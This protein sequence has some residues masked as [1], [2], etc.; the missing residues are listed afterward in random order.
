MLFIYN[1]HV[2]PPPHIACKAGFLSLFRHRRLDIRTDNSLSDA[3][4]HVASGKDM[5]GKGS[6]RPPAT[7]GA[8]LVNFGRLLHRVHLPAEAGAQRRCAGRLGQLNRLTPHQWG[9]RFPCPTTKTPSHYII[10]GAPARAPS[11]RRYQADHIFPQTGRSMLEMLAVLAIMGVLAIGGIAAYSFA[12][13]KHRANQIYNQVDLR[14]IASFGNPFVR[15]ATTGQT[16]PLAGFDEVVESIT[17]QHKKTAGNGYDIIASHVPERVCRR[18]QDMTFPVPKSVTLN[19]A[20]LSSTCGSDNTFVFSYDGLSIGKPS[21]GVDP[22]DCTCSG[23]QSCESGVCRDND[24]LCGPKEVCVSGTCQCAPGYTECRGSCYTACADG[25]MRDPVSCDCVCEP[26]DCPEHAS[27]DS[28]TCSCVC[29]DGYEMCNGACHPVC[30]GSGMTG[31]R[32]PDTCACT[33]IEGTDAATCACP[34]GYIYVNGQCQRFECRGGPTSYNCYI[35]ELLC[36]YNC[37]SLGHN[38]SSGTCYADECPDEFDF[39]FIPS[40]WQTSGGYRYG[41]KVPGKECYKI[42]PTDN[43]TFCFASTGIYPCCTANVNGACVTGL[44]DNNL[45]PAGSTLLHGTTATYPYFQYGGCLFENGVKCY[46]TNETQTLWNCQASTGVTCDTACTNPPECNGNCAENMCLDGQTYD[47]ETGYCCKGD[48]CC[49]YN[50]DTHKECYK[51]NTRCATRCNV[52]QPEKCE[53]GNCADPGCAAFGMTYGYIETEKVWG[54]LDS[55]LGISGMACHY[56]SDYKPARCL[57]NKKVCGLRC[58]YDGSDCKQVYMSEC[59]P[60]GECL[61]NGALVDGCICNTTTGQVTTI[62]DKSYCCPAGHIYTNGGCTLTT[63]DDGQIA[64][65]NGICRDA[66]ENNAEVTSTCVC[67][68]STHT[69]KFNRTICCDANHAWDET[70]ETCV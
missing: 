61:Q 67:G 15:Q 60:V 16:Y 66:C 8:T 41:C 55:D 22:I 37:D 65:E 54:C 50:H 62:G 29:E 64:D 69:D 46:P 56:L 1:K 23:C 28:S 35:N 36:G 57:F 7:R 5:T 19:G 17:Y 4:I 31:S 38:C 63:C 42:T 13:S 20:D 2:T 24:N 39:Q 32:D 3:K 43:R 12:V 21:S 25:F 9:H 52:T 33:C 68:G 30:D 34:A 51:G 53:Y 59:M 49:D 26:Q 6:P 70:T 40:P 44:C 58:N 10:G 47:P 11:P 14:A 45:C 18:L 48:I 27:W